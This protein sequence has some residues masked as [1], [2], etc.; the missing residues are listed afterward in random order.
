[1]EKLMV[2]SIGEKVRKGQPLY[3][4]YSEQLLAAQ[5]EYLLAL[6]Q[7]SIN[8]GGLKQDLA[9]SSRQKLLLWGMTN[10]QIDQ[11]TKTGKASPRVTFYSPVS[12]NIMELA[13]REGSY[14]TEGSV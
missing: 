14:V 4:I 8:L 3:Q 2:W 13:F 9:A 10:G 12:G 1:I 7:E 5:Q 11:L 6:Q